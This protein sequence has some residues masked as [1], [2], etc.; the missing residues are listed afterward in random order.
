MPTF[1]LASF[2]H[3]Y[4][5]SKGPPDSR[6]SVS[7]ISRLLHETKILRRPFDVQVV[8]LEIKYQTV[9][10]PPILYCILPLC[11]ERIDASRTSETDLEVTWHVR[12]FWNFDNL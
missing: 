1:D 10:G 11:P 5:I 12:A 4:I 2:K 6:Y 3:N 7:L 8:H 9:D